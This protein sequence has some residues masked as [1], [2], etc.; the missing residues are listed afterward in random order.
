MALRLATG[1]RNALLGKSTG[2]NDS[3]KD[4]F[5]DGVLEIYSGAQPT[6]PDAAET[7]TKLV[8]I[9]VSSGAFTP[10]AATN[11]LEFGDA[12]SGAIAK[13]AAETWS[14]VVLATGVAGWFRFYDNDYDDGADATA[15]RF[16]GACGT[17]GA[18]LILSSTSMTA[19]ATITIDSFSITLPAVA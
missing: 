18:Q 4:L 11:G 12:A 14:G 19:G 10:G 5:A 13:A 15:I 3:F 8:R 17:S 6:D 7:G 1:L 9:T 16:D 2:D